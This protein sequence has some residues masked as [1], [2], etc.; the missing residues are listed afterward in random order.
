[1]KELGLNAVRHRIWVDPAKQ[2]IP[3]SWSGHSYEQMKED[4]W[5]HTVDVLNYLSVVM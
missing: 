3:E 2:N 1:M 4:L 5:N